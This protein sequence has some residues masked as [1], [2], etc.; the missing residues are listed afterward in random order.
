MGDPRRNRKVSPS[1]P[2]AEWPRDGDPI[3]SGVVRLIPPG[4]DAVIVLVRH[5]ETEFIVEGRFQGQM[6]TPLTRRG[7]LQLGFTGHRVAHP[8]DDPPLPIPDTAPPCGRLA[9]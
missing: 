2:N 3:A 1:L 6:E 9:D 7:E 4:L 5:G 8:Q